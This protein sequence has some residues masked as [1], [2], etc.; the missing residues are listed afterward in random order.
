MELRMLNV[1]ELERICRE[2]KGFWTAQGSHM[3][4]T[5]KMY[6]IQIFVG[7]IDKDSPVYTGIA[8]DIDSAMTI[9]LAK[10]DKKDNS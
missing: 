7:Q 8:N 9:A 4:G 1:T 10:Y 5:D 2:T 6:T 3:H